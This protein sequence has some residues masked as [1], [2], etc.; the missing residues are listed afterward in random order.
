MITS[1]DGLAAPDTRPDDTVESGAADGS[2]RRVIA[3]A[4]GLSYAGL[5]GDGYVRELASSHD[6]ELLVTARAH[7]DAPA[8]L[9]PGVA[10]RAAHLLDRALAMSTEPTG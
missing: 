3:L 10:E 9:P 1:M 2:E 4:L 5:D 6:R 7:L 8:H